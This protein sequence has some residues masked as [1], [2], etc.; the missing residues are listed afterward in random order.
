M[1]RGLAPLLQR[2]HSCAGSIL[3]RI[4]TAGFAKKKG[5]DEDVGSDSSYAKALKASTPAP[6]DMC[7]LVYHLCPTGFVKGRLQHLRTLYSDHSSH[8]FQPFF[9]KGHPSS[10][11]LAYADPGAQAKGEDAKAERGR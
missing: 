8:P 7:S 2:Q 9:H 10:G 3:P 11:C 1:L 6:M 5:G 4:Q